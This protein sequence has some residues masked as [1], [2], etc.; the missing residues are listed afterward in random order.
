VSHDLLGGQTTLSQG[1]LK[2]VGQCRFF[3][4]LHSSSTITVVKLVME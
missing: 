4:F 1:S 3:F 2:T